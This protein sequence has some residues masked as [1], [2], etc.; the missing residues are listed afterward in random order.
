MSK[1]KMTISL[2][3]GLA[4][5]LRSTPSISSTIAEAVE[6]YRTREME[7]RLEQAYRED[8]AEAEHLNKAWE[9]ADAEPEP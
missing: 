9:S 5:Y 2:N 4:E 8:A 6:V 1:V 3:Q 7:A